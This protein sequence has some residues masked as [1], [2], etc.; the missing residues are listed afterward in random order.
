MSENTACKKRKEKEKTAVDSH[1]YG[2]LH[3]MSCLPE[4]KY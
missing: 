2:G 4:S 3:F 1:N